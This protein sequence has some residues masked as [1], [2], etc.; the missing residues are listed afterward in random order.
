MSDGLE[1]VFSN[2]EVEAIVTQEGLKSIQDLFNFFAEALDIAIDWIREY[3][4]T[5]SDEEVR[6][7]ISQQVTGVGIEEIVDK[8]AALTEIQEDL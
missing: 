2:E 4:P 1:D 6:G 5:M 8:L 3:E 7:I